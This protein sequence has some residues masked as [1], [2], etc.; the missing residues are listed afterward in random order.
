M[1]RPRSCFSADYA[2][3][4]SHVPQLAGA[5]GAVSSQDDSRGLGLNGDS[6]VIE[7]ASNDGYLLKNFV[8]AGIPC[9]GIEPTASTAAAAEKIGGAGAARVFRGERGKGAGR[10]REARRP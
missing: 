1:R 4:S 3:F 6:L 10:C 7:M 8:A 5:R 2:Y 9:L